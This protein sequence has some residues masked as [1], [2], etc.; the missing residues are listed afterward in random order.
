M[1][2]ISVNDKKEILLSGTFD[3]SQVQKALPVFESIN[4]SVTVD[5]RDLDYISSA[6]LGVFVVTHKRLEKLGKTMRLT[7]MNRQIRNVFQ[8]SGL[9]QVFKI[10]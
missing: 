1:L 9:H 8:I 10:E 4:D 5:L 6:G 2:N 7:N 3:A